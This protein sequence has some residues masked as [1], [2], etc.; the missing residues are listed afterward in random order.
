MKIKIINAYDGHWYRDYIDKVFEVEKS[1]TGYTLIYT[2][3]N[4]TII[5]QE[6]DIERR[7]ELLKRVRNIKKN[8]LRLGVS[9]E[10]AVEITNGN[11]KDFS[12]LLSRGW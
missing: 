6:P 4:E 5:N 3:E 7:A 1:I 11:N 2:P 9:G 8:G 12:S 10:N